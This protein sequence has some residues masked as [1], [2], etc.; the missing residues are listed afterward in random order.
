[1]RILIYFYDLFRPVSY[2]EQ[3]YLLDTTSNEPYTAFNNLIHPDDLPIL[4]RIHHWAFGSV[5]NIDPD[6]R[7]DLMLFYTLRLRLRDNSFGMSRVSVKVLET[8]V[9]GAIWLVLFV[10][11]KNKSDYY[12]QPYISFPSSKNNYYPLNPSI[13]GRL[14]LAEQ[15]LIP[16]LFGYFSINDIASETG[17][18]P[19]TIKDHLRHIKLKISNDDRIEMQRE[20]LYAYECSVC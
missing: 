13:V 7:N 2:F 14:T 20:L 9:N 4:H 8:D 11:E 1:L 5:L 6:K 3:K 10:L 16:Y 12:E 15:Q 18:S 17:K 19:H